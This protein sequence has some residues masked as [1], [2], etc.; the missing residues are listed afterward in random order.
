MKV[1][2]EELRSAF[3]QLMKYVEETRG[4]SI[5]LQ[6]DLYWYIPTPEVYNFKSG[7]TDLVLGSLEDNWEAI[8]KIGRHEKEPLEYALVWMASLLRL[9]GEYGLTDLPPDEAPR[10]DMPK[11]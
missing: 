9:L 10:D 11:S 5:D 4:A 8:S 3:D 7:P 6:K 2:L 1:Q